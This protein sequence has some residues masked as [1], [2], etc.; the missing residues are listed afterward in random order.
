MQ[1]FNVYKENKLTAELI[2]QTVQAKNLI[3]YE[4]LDQVEP[5][6]L[7]FFNLVLSAPFKEKQIANYNLDDE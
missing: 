5:I 6:N 7:Q 3:D 2:S 4:T 1:I